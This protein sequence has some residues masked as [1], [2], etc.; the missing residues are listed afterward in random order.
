[1][2]NS[3]AHN[4]AVYEH[5]NHDEQQYP[6]P[7][8]HPQY[9]GY[10]DMNYQSQYPQPQELPYHQPQEESFNYNADTSSSSTK[11]K[12]LANGDSIKSESLPDS[13]HSTLYK[14]EMCKHFVETGTCRY[15]TVCQFAHGPEQLRDVLRHPKY[16]TTKCKVY[17]STGHCNYGDRCRFIHEDQVE[18]PEPAPSPKPRR[19]KKALKPKSSMASSSATEPDALWP[20]KSTHPKYRTTK[21]HS[22]TKTG[23]C[24]Y[25]D[26]C[27]FIHEDPVVRPASK[28]RAPKSLNPKA[29][30]FTLPGSAFKSNSFLIEA[31]TEQSTLRNKFE[32]TA[33]CKAY[34]TN[35]HCGYGARCGF[36][37]ED[38]VV[39]SED[40]KPVLKTFDSTPSF[41]IEAETEHS[42]LR[43]TGRNFKAPSRS[44]SS[45]LLSSPFSSP[46]FQPQTKDFGRSSPISSGSTTSSSS[47]STSGLELPAAPGLELPTKSFRP[48][49]SSQSLLLPHDASSSTSSFLVKSKSQSAY[50]AFDRM[51]SF[52]SSINDFG[53][54]AQQYHHQD[55][56]LSASESNTMLDDLNHHPSLAEIGTWAS[57]S[58]SNSTVASDVDQHL[59]QSNYGKEL[60]KDME[61][62]EEDPGM[63]NDLFV[64][65]LSIFETICE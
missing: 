24:S 45:P 34:S 10:D 62:V 37:H 28:S 33:K 47:S 11:M 36:I 52:S 41:L 35:G 64:S 4:T 50:G 23:Q 59:P 2:N 60:R 20:L 5:S 8:D 55:S 30:K 27:G 43:N 26:R 7:Y 46:I 1:M 38:Q 39:D 14:T 18:E 29:S 40:S 17:E 56:S 9:S 16:R 15:D 57:S 13:A 22:Y 49:C 31:A 21:C 54:L 6:Y 3:H 32:P 51:D 58:S 25:G 44:Y 65:R 63:I 48:F 19:P 61:P 12:V 42:T 53:F